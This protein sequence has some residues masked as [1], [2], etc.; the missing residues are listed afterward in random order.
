MISENILFQHLWQEDMVAHQHQ[1]G[2]WK[3]PG[4]GGQKPQNQERAPNSSL[5]S[6][7]KKK[8]KTHIIGASDISY[9]QG[10][11]ENPYLEKN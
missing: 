9:N 10:D 11:V 7:V 2:Q 1:S 6:I 4:I 8:K 3:P 5:I